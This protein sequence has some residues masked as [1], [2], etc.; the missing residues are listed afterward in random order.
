MLRRIGQ[1]TLLK[2]VAVSILAYALMGFFAQMLSIKSFDPL[3]NA[4]KSFSFTDIYYQILSETS[5]PDTSR[6]VTI[7]DITS[8]YRRGDMAQVLMDIESLKPKAVGVDV[9]FDLE[10]DDFDGNDSLIDV[11]STYDNIVFS[12]KYQDFDEKTNQFTKEIHSF[13][14]NYIDVKEGYCNVARGSLYDSTKRT[15]TRRT[16]SM[17]EEKPSLP[18]H[19]LS[20][21]TGIDMS[22]G[23]ATVNINFSP[24]EFSV[25]TPDQILEHPE[26][27]QDRIVMVG[28]MYEAADFHWTPVGKIAG[29]KL[30]AYG[31]Q[32]LLEKKEVKKLPFTSMC[33][34][35]F[36]VTLMFCYFRQTYASLTGSSKSLFV[37]FIIGSSYIQSICTFLISSTLLGIGFLTFSL[38]SIS[39]NLTWALSSIAFLGTGASLYSAL[40]D[41]SLNKAQSKKK[42]K[43]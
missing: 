41:Y 35:S 24:K 40:S 9:V 16:C 8:V 30:L 38:F 7:V 17:G 6:V 29:V 12:V 23:E 19:T 25:L 31:M 1:S 15:L 43:L 2:N 13:F 27:I 20:V 5:E 26:L 32:T 42:E 39:I 4:L 34:L 11:A 18:I 22:E 3:S 14:T 36:L 33:V 28:A 37:R 10:K 21:Y